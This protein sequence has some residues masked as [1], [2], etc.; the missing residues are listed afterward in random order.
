MGLEP[1][2]FCAHAPK[3][4][5]MCSPPVDGP[6]YTFLKQNEANPQNQDRSR[7]SS[8]Y[9]QH[10]KKFLHHEEIHFEPVRPAFL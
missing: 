2:I 5:E 10:S 7:Q 9:Q 1:L 3:R 8:E 4:Y 6:E